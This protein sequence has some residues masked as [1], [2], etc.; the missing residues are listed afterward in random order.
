MPRS[1][2]S[3]RDP[4]FLSHFWQELFKLSGTKLRMSTAYHPQSDGQTEIVNKVLQQYLRCFVHNKPKQWGQYLH[5]AE[6]HYNTSIHTATGFSPFQIVYGRPP[7]TLSDYIPGST[8][9]QAVEATLLDRDSILQILKNKLQKAQSMMKTAADQHRISHKFAVGD[10]AFVKLR[11]YRQIS[12]AGRRVHKLSKRYYGPY[13]LI[14][15][16]G[17]VAF[18]LEL[19]PTSKI[20]PVFHV[21]QLKP[22]LGD[23]AAT[24]DLPPNAE[25]N[26]PIIQPLSVLDWKYNTEANEWQVLIQW[27]GLFPEDSTWES[28]QEILTNYP[29]FHLEDKVTLD[30]PGNVM[31]QDESNGPTNENVVMVPPPKDKRNVTL[32]PHFKDFVMPA[33]KKG[34]NK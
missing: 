2:V 23:T 34:N 1:I 6:W 12:V 15:A 5:W 14:K 31:T 27:E 20:H 13:K 25:E 28:Y 4:I 10:F 26:H 3:D 30:P 8:Q 11:P 18:Q 7:P 17:E 21:S 9:L 19:P 22:C 24:L 32:P 16:I 29:A 33:W